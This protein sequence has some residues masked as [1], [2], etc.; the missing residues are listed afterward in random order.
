M[1]E[2]LVDQPRRRR[3]EQGLKS[4]ATEVVRE[5]GGLVE[6]P[7]VPPVEFATEENPDK[8]SGGHKVRKVKRTFSLSD[9]L[10]SRIDSVAAA[11]KVDPCDVVE[12]LL[13]P[14]LAGVRPATV[15][16]ALKGTIAPKGRSAA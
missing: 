1:T 2:T 9:R 11:L 16:E 8:A 4:L 14:A 10:S 12:R 3:I 15:P 7:A 13:G 6:A 5:E